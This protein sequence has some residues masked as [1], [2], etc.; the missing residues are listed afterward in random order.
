MSIELLINSPKCKIVATKSL[1][2]AAHLI[3]LQ[4]APGISSR[5]DVQLPAEL[6]RDSM[7]FN[8][9]VSNA[10]AQHRMFNDC[11]RSHHHEPLHDGRGF[12]T[13]IV[14]V[15]VAQLGGNTQAWQCCALY[16]LDVPTRQ[17]R[18]F[19]AIMVAADH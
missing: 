6:C 10:L 15:A 16:S 19:N 18:V 14:L 1:D 4:G 8:T 17:A 13:F 12:F 3:Y 11:G 5:H 9:P 2:A 7:L